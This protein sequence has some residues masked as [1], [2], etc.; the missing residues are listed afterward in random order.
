[1]RGVVFCKP[2]QR[3]GIAMGGNALKNVKTSRLSAEV[4]HP[5]AA[6]LTALLRE[7]FGARAEVIP[8][9][10][11]KADFGDLD[12]IVEQEKV[13]VPGDGYAALRAFAER[14]GFARQFSANGSVLSYDHRFSSEDDI[15][16]QVD[17]IITPASEIDAALSYFSFNDLGNLIGRSAHKMGF[18]YGHLG[19]LYPFRDG[20]HLF[21]T[22]EVTS[23]TDEALSFIGYDPA[24][25][26]QGFNNLPEIFD[27][28]TGSRYFNPAIFLLENRNHTSR[29]RDS[30]RK[31]YSAF[32]EHIA[33]HQDT[34]SAFEFP[35]DKAAW[36][37]EAFE[38]FPAFKQSYEAA[39][40]ELKDV[41]FIR[42]VFNGEQVIAWTGLEGKQVGGVM[43]EVKKKF[44]GPHAFAE[45]LREHGA[46]GA[47]AL[48][49]EV[50]QAQSKPAPRG[51]RL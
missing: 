11:E 3:L 47:R 17:L 22:L 41:R 6:K 10:T 21:K 51:P 14:H 29:V 9:Y 30:K 5:L 18:K 4:F 38:R 15:G 46:D 26:H 24:R 32:L 42:S 36:L 33:A 37:P 27:Y 25:F 19:L 8:A 50:I 48:V 23:S 20:D 44:D 49:E 16:F 40:Q 45:F 39:G 12:L 1:M 13:L 31:T 43:G 34:L 35:E 2:I 28:V 7:E